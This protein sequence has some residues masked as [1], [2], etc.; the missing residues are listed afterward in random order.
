M[1]SNMI[2]LPPI[3]CQALPPKQVG[4][5]LTLIVFFV[6]LKQKNYQCKEIRLSGKNKNNNI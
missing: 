5:F 1:K 6:F 2:S 3:M 4:D